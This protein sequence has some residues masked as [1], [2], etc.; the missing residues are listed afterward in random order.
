MQNISD[1]QVNESDKIE[2]L[3]VAVEE[4]PT[5]FH[6]EAES[7]AECSSNR[8]WVSCLEP[9]KLQTLVVGPLHI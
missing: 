4:N 7:L 2:L 9:G 1:I 8:A 6:Y 3:N 5:G